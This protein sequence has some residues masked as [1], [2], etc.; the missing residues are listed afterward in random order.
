MNAKTNRWLGLVWTLVRTDFKTRYHGTAGGFLWALLKPAAMFVVLLAVFSLVFANTRTYSLD[1]IVGLFL[2][3][4]FAEATKVGLTSL[5]AKGYLLSKARFPAWV[6]VV[7]SL[8]NALIT[9]LIFSLVTF[10]YLGLSRGRLPALGAMAWFGFYLLSLVLITIG[11]SLATSVLFLRYRD[12]NQVWEVMLQVGFFVAPII[13]PLA[14]IPERLHRFLYM[15]PPTPIIQFSRA[16]LIDGVVP[17]SRAH[18]LL[19]AGV[20]ASLAVGASV[21]RRLAPRAVEYL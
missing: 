4:F 15:W 11:F 17:S 2:W 20:V 14:V 21:Y 9:S 1:L 16:V 12:L 19:A 5:H 7:S 3:D 18:G 13:Y 8:S 10:L 6:L